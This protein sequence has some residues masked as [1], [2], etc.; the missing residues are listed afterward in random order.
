M[1]EPADN[2]VLTERR[3]HVMVLTIN[4]PQKRNAFHNP[5][6]Q[7][8]ARAV[9]AAQADRSVRVLLITGAGDTF[10]AGQDFSEMSAESGAEHGFPA[11]L[12]ALIDCDKPIVTA[13]NGVGIGL[14]LTM[15]LHTDVNYIARGARLRAPFVTLGVVPEAAASYLLP[16]VVGAQKAA[17]ILYTARWIEA[18]ECVELGIALALVE[19]DRLLSTALAKAEEIA[20]NP[21]QAVRHT[22]RLLRVW[23]RQAILEA[24]AREDQAFQERLG[25]PE[26]MEAIQAFFEK[27]APDFSKL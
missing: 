4:R 13:V 1:S 23:R 7:A 19:P 27:R 17:E 24:R 16:I 25:T 12:Q 18:E 6:Y 2:L 8:M 15:L 10:C 3:G 9:L 22:K 5:L 14:G 21:P 26:N 11:F 20:A